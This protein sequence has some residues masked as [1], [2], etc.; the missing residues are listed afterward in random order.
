MFV[1]FWID[2]YVH[3][4]AEMAKNYQEEVVWS[5][6]KRVVAFSLTPKSKSLFMPV[7]NSLHSN[8]RFIFIKWLTGEV[9]T[10]NAI[11]LWPIEIGGQC[12]YPPKQQMMNGLTLNSLNANFKKLKAAQIRTVA[13]SVVAALYHKCCKSISSV[14][15]NHDHVQASN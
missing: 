9:I 6:Q 4:V 12:I 7:H 3:F 5:N 1:K 14:S 11:F 15:K 13:C 10:I 2:L 8:S